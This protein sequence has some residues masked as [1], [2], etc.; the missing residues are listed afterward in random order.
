[1]ISGAIEVLEPVTK[2]FI[3]QNNSAME[4]SRQAVPVRKMLLLVMSWCWSV[5]GH[6]IFLDYWLHVTW[7]PQNCS[8]FVTISHTYLEN[9]QPSEFPFI[10]TLVDSFH[11][12]SHRG[13]SSGFNSDIYKQFMP[14]GFNTQGREQLHAKIERLKPS[15]S[16][17]NYVS[18]MTMYKIFFGIS[19]LKAKGII[20]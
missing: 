16:Q 17:M 9:R 2:I 4:C 20:Q 19:N 11:Y 6:I 1:M 15:F 12:K 3:N 10:R 14:P 13:C 7:T 5:K 18:T 8:A